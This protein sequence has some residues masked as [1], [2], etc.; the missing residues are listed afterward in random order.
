MAE[1]YRHFA[2]QTRCPLDFSEEAAREMYESETHGKGSPSE[3]NGYAIGKRWMDVTLANWLEDL[4]T[5][6]LLS[7]EL[8]LDPNYPRWW[9]DRVLPERFRLTLEE[10]EGVR[11]SEA[12]R[13]YL[14]L[15]GE[16]RTLASA[17]GLAV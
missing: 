2:K 13:S 15:D 16:V 17:R 11:Q 5:P 10:I 9:L 1:V 3:R 8:Y 7:W 6:L 12:G 14:R 4:G